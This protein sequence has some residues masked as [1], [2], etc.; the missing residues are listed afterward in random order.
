MVAG[1]KKDRLIQSPEWI[2]SHHRD[3]KIMGIPYDITL[4]KFHNNNF[5]DFLSQHLTRI[6][7]EDLADHKR[8]LAPLLRK[9]YKS[10][11]QYQIAMCGCWERL[12]KTFS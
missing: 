7:A 4:R 12:C 3:I 8:K 2:H 9:Q 10:N 5:C 11:I 1:L 6:N